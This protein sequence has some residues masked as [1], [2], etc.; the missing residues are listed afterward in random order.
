MGLEVLIKTRGGHETPGISEGDQ[1]W[2]VLDA[3]SPGPSGASSQRSLP[4]VGD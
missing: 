4:P 3:A 2:S 1:G